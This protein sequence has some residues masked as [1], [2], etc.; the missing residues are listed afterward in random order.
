MADVFQTSL[1]SSFFL[2]RLL[3]GS[4][5]G[6]PVYL[7]LAIVGGIAGLI[8]TMVVWPGSETD[9]IAGISAALV[10]A[11]GTIVVYDRVLGSMA[12]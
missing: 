12:G 10:G 4:W 5:L 7:A 3:K 6:N 1:F 9:F 11:W 2:V 8:V